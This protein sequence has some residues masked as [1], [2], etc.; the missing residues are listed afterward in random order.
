MSTNSIN[1]K[2]KTIYSTFLGLL[3]KKGKK[4][5]AKNLLD[6]AFSKIQ[7]ISKLKINTVLNTLLSKLNTHVEIRKIKIRKNT[8]I[9]PFPLKNKRR[10][11]LIIKWIL[12]SIEEDKRKVSYSKKLSEEILSI[13]SN[14]ISKTLTKKIYNNEQAVKNRSNIHYRW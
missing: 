3:T 5:V 9:V 11:Y 10:N 4:T 13:I 2:E 12:N 1:N 7:K 8:H 6:D 14:K